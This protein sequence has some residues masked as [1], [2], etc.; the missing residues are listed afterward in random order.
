MAEP[1]ADPS[2]AE[3]ARGEVRR[4]L[5]IFGAVLAVLSGVPLL[6]TSLFVLPTFA[7]MFAELGSELPALTQLALNRGLV[8]CLALV[9]PVLA[10]LALGG[11]V[12]QRLRLPAIGAAILFGLVSEALVV[13][14]LYLPIFAMADAISAG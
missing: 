13:V 1:A 11:V 4:V 6:A 5:S 9:P 7:A 12:P 10:G 2:P 8:A 14:A 3:A